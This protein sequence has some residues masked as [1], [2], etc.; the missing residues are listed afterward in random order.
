M[1]KKSEASANVKINSVVHKHVSGEKK[2][3]VSDKSDNAEW[4]NF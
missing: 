4:E 2:K 3:S 1:N